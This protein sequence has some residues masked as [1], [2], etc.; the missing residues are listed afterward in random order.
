MR[1]DAKVGV[2]SLRAKEMQ[3]VARADEAV[4]ETIVVGKRRP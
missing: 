4:D 2:G 3:F 1:G